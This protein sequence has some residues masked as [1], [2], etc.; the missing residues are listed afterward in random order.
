MNTPADMHLDFWQHRNVAIKGSGTS[1]S[2]P[3]SVPPGFP[4]GLCL[5]HVS[6]LSFIE[7]YASQKYELL[8]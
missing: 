2:I 6:K 8:S 1:R 3:D 7:D 5:L 4:L